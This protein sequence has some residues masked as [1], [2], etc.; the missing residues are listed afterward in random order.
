MLCSDKKMPEKLLPQLEKNYAQYWWK[1]DDE[2]DYREA[3][4]DPFKNIIFT[5]LSQNTSSQNTRKAYLGLKS[6]FEV[7]PQRLFTADERE[8][9]KAIQPGGLHR[10]KAKRIKEISE[11]VLKNFNGDLSW[12]FEMPKEKVR[13]EIMKLPGIGDKTADV[14]V[15]SIHGQREAFVIDTHMARI[16]RR[17][18]LVNEN[19][20]YKEIQERLHCFFPW[21]KIEKEREERVVG[22]FWLLAKHTCTAR[23]AYCSECILDEICEK[24]I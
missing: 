20:S 22:L 21:E 23:K 9:R 17:L 11:Y 3:M 14:L 4:K 8:I 15:S 18:G 12:V 2:S 1:D 7:M 13:E 24:I 19:T 5:L 10:I 16:A 6:H